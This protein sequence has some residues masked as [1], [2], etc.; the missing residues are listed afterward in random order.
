MLDVGCRVFSIFSPGNGWIDFDPTNNCQPAEDYITVAHGRDFG[1]VSPV[2]GIL[3]GGG[4]HEVKVS[5][6]VEEI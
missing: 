1:D 6:D 4:K 2:A 3:T 5:V